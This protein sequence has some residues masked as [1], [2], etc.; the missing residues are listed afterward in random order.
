MESIATCGA[1]ES[2]R[3]KRCFVISRSTFPGSGS[4]TGHWTGR[5]YVTEPVKINHVSTKKSPIFSVF[6]VS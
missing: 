6:A 4:H 2:I 5:S 1:L 3:E